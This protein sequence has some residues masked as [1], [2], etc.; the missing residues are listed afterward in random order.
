MAAL[1]TNEEILYALITSSKDEIILL[2]FLKEQ[3]LKC[4]LFVGT[5]TEWVIFTFQEFKIYSFFI[6]K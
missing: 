1:K 5:E 3:C 4:L 6:T 2:E